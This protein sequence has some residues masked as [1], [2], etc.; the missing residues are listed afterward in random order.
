MVSIAP[1]FQNEED[2]LFRHTYYDKETGTIRTSNNP[3]LNQ[4]VFKIMTDSILTDDEATLFEKISKKV[5]PGKNALEAQGEDDNIEG[6]MKGI[7]TAFLN[8]LSDKVM[9]K[10]GNLVEGNLK[11]AAQFIDRKDFVLMALAQN[12]NDIMAR[13]TAWKHFLIDYSTLGV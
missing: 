11:K 1:T 13:A 9:A 10:Y 8:T 3:I 2:A 6:Q 5:K 7:L 12:Q 4:D